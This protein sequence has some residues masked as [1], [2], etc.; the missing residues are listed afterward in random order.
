LTF[1]GEQAAREALTVV[2]D[3]FQWRKA[4]QP[5]LDSIIQRHW[6]AWERDGVPITLVLSGSALTMME[7]LLEQGAPLYGRARS[8]SPPTTSRDGSNDWRLSATSLRAR[9]WNATASSTG[10]ST[11]SQTPTSGSGSGMSCATAAGWRADASTRSTTRSPPTLT[12]SWARRSNSSTRSGRPPRKQLTQRAAEEN[13][14]LLTTGDLF[15]G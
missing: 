11:R 14:Q 7:G 4:A 1:F 8:G 5:A 6:D 9:R 13:V 10:P 12:T 15:A 3:E 2:L